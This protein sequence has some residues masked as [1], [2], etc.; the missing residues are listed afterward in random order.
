M[1]RSQAHSVL[2]LVAWGDAGTQ[3]AAKAGG[4]KTINH[5]DAEFFLVLVGLYSRRTTIAYGE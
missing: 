1:G 4:I 5:L 3:A 2:W